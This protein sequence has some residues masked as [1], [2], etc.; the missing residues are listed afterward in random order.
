MRSFNV[1]IVFFLSFMLF[2]ACSDEKDFE[3]YPK[4][5]DSSGIVSGENA[6]A[7]TVVFKDTLVNVMKNEGVVR[8]P[9]VASEKLTDSVQLVIKAISEDG[10]VGKDFVVN[11]VVWVSK[12]SVNGYVEVYLV[13]DAKV[14]NRLAFTLVL[15]ETK[16][17]SALIKLGHAIRCHVTVENNALISFSKA[18]Y[19]TWEAAE[20]LS[21]PFRVI[22]ELTGTTRVT[23]A[24]KESDHPN[25]ALEENEVGPGNFRIDEK[26]VT[27]EAG[28]T[29]GAVVIQLIDDKEVNE[30]RFFDLWITSIEGGNGRL[31]TMDTLCRVTIQSEEIAKVVRFAETE[32]MVEE[33]VLTHELL[34]PVIMDLRADEPV[35]VK[36]TTEDGTA[37][38][39]EDFQLLVDEV[40]IPAG[41]TVVD[42]R[43]TITDDKLVTGDRDFKLKIESVTGGNAS[44]ANVS[45][46]R[47]IIVDDDYS[48]NFAQLSYAFNEDATGKTIRL[49]STK[50]LTYDL[51]LSLE[52]KEGGTAVKGAH[53]DL[54]AQVVIPAGQA[55]VDVPVTLIP[56]P[57]VT[58]DRNF[59]FHIT[60]ADNTSAILTDSD[61]TVTIKEI[62]T[63]KSINFAKAQYIFMENAGTAS[64]EL[65]LDK[66]LPEDV[67]L[68]ISGYDVSYCSGPA[69]VTIP[70][71]QTT[72]NI[73]L[74]LVDDQVFNADRE[75]NLT[76]GSITYG[77]MTEADVTVGNLSVSKIIIANDDLPEWS[78]TIQAY[79]FEESSG[80]Q[81]ITVTLKQSYDA[82]ITVYL[83]PVGVTTGTEIAEITPVTIPAGSTS[84][85][86]TVN[87][88]ANPLKDPAKFTLQIVKVNNANYQTPVTVAEITPTACQYRK[89]LGNWT[90][91]AESVSNI[92]N[93]ITVTLIMGTTDAEK[94]ANFNKKFLCRGN[95]MNNLSFQWSFIFEPETRA[96]NIVMNEKVFHSSL[97]DGTTY[98]NFVAYENATGYKY[99]HM[100]VNERGTEIKWIDDW[101]VNGG[102]YKISDNSYS[103]SWFWFHKVTMT[104]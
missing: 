27:L 91:K 15:T 64:V 9:V 24:V 62:D 81:T 44:S 75:I 103:A 25:A 65:T 83:A 63:Q 97:D 88:M 39:G 98:C 36:L 87:M 20:T 17:N 50:T 92:L 28:A 56:D 60:A 35:T 1:I 69:S 76:L 74:T 29:E 85:N 72:A 12:D 96:M 70:K 104:R 6:P 82:D 55:Y 99:Y 34:I 79:S 48:I 57:Y 14:D 23:V 19:S 13:D 54:P 46:C 102:V 40:V 5:E 100:S 32:Y 84:G 30:D 51:T 10:V 47:V 90:W 101:F 4:E 33:N 67:T 94:K 21:I 11:E 26:T 86:V 53:F 52:V 7:A 41:D 59:I 22:G 89:M 43:I 66:S 16:E 80:N 31:G 38:V 71:G 73:S 68:A 95:L 61:C 8:I 78:S 42:V 18:S 3:G 77:K 49:N 2:G 93:P 58:G 45:D 37:K